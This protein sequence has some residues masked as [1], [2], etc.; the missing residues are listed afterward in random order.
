MKTIG[1]LFFRDPGDTNYEALQELGKLLGIDIRLPTLHDESDA[2]WANAWKTMDDL[3]DSADALLLL[4][5][6]VLR[7]QADRLHNRIANGTR[8]FVQS[9]INDVGLLNQFLSPNSIATTSYK[10]LSHDLDSR[11]LTIPNDPENFL[12]DELL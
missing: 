2:S 1:A 12:D 10:I 3:I 5:P 4:D 9:R 11:T 8:V 6:F 7:S